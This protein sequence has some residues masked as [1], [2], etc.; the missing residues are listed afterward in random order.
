M[1]DSIEVFEKVLQHYDIDSPE[2]L[3]KI[4]CPFHDDKNASLQVNKDKCF[5]YCY[6]CG[7]KGSSIDLV[8]YHHPDWSDLRCQMY[9]SKI[10][11]NDKN[12]VSVYTRNKT[13]LTS[14]DS[15]ENSKSISYLQG[16]KQAKSYFDSLPPINWYKPS[17]K[18]DGSENELNGDEAIQCK[19]YMKQRGFT[20]HTL[21]KAKA[22]PS[23][24]PYYPI[25]FPL[26]E[27]GSFKGYV[28]RTFDK[29]I[30]EKRK[31]MYNRGFKRERTLAGDYEAEKPLVV[32]EG[33]LDCIKAKQ[34]GLKNVVALLGWK[35]TST[36]LKKIKRAKIP[37][38]L[39]ALDNDECGRKGYRYLKLVA[40]KYGFKVKRICYPSNKKDFG[41]LNESNCSQIISQIKR[42]GGK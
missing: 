20:A 22:K 11:K 39:C 17:K 33:Y 18:Y 29:Q 28:M 27:N 24:N 14:N 13:S 15:V 6:G 3:Y 35:I 38:I 16:I 34:L 40:N 42:Y 25:C 5:W 4:L 10:C 41:D 12:L 36:Q 2:C 23:L 19:Q 1:Q 30:E 21:T 32:V 37:L 9:V 8:K 31:Y 7:A 26:L